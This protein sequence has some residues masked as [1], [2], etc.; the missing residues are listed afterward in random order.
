MLIE[1]RFFLGTMLF[2]L[3]GCSIISSAAVA[4]ALDPQRLNVRIGRTVTIID[5]DSQTGLNHEMLGMIR[6]PD[7]TI[8][9]R[10]QNRGILKSEDEGR[11][12]KGL[13]VNFPGAH[14]KQTL[15]GLYAS[16]N[17]VLWLMH[18]SSGGKDLFVSRSRDRG[19]T[20]KTSSIDYSNLAPG[21]PEDPYIFCFNDYN[22][23]FQRPDGTMVLGIGLRYEDHGNYQQKDQSRP[24]FH[25]TLIRSEDGGETWG[26]PTEVHPHVAETGYA[27]D[28]QNPDRIL[29]FTRKQRMLLLGEDPVEVGKAAGV[30]SDTSWP[31]KGA[32]LLESIDGGRSFSEVPHSYLGSYSHRGT[33]LW[34]ETNVVIVSSSAG[35]H[36]VDGR[37]L[38]RISLDGAR[39]WV[40]GTVSGTTRLN[41]ATK[42]VLLKPPPTISFTSPMV[43]LSPNSFL[44]VYA[45]WNEEALQ[46]YRANGKDKPWV[47]FR[48]L[49]F[50]LENAPSEL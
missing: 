46:K 29:A 12:W 9:I 47:G 41:Q 24:G 35:R 33:I 21:A 18:Q 43:Q 15:H 39:T 20:W 31:W 45:Y 23:F 49:F 27:V 30:P 8:F 40:D 48:G 34:T 50:R 22:T 13:P 1:I 16:R 19:V 44:V 17:G 14:P 11:T 3:V 26:D 2:G 28:P 38:A 10:T 5:A 6:H 42:F 36:T 32:I 7:G 37:R 4:N 25:E